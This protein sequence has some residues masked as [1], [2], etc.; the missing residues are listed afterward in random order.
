[1]AYEV[2]PNGYWQNHPPEDEPFTRPCRECTR[3]SPCPCGNC[4]WGFCAEFGEYVDGSDTEE[5]EYG[6]GC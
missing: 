2:D 1:M 3:F 4:D 5:C 6:G